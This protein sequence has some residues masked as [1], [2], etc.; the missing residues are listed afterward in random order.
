ML[1]QTQLHS[2]NMLLLLFSYYTVEACDNGGAGCVDEPPAQW[3]LK[4][5]D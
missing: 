3:S 5:H 1:P 2:F 4:V